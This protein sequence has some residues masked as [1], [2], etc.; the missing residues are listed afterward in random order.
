MSKRLIQYVIAGLCVSAILLMAAPPASASDW[1]KKTIITVN[2]PFE[3]PGKVL[4]A[5]SYVFKII[6]LGSNRNVVRISSADEKTIYATII[7][8]PDFKL[9]PSEK[10]DISF[11]ESAAGQPRPLHAW[12]YPA[13]QFGVEF[14]YPRKRAVEIAKVSDEHV[15]AESAAAAVEPAREPTVKE[16]LAE[17]LV[18]IE[19]GGREVELAELHPMTPTAP[20]TP[21]VSR[22]LPKTASPLALFGLIGVLAAG[23]ASALRF[24]R[25]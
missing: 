17:P 21:E 25:G 23:A 7:G 3:I 15:I 11:Y 10:T 8:I 16:L 13:Q 2:Q 20:L 4:P 12:F 14:A 18:G 19:P 6:D 9:K 24:F 22:E 5:G 1:D